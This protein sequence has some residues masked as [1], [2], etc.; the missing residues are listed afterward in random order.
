MTGLNQLAIN[1]VYTSRNSIDNNEKGQTP[2][3][4]TTKTADNEYEA[5][6]NLRHFGYMS[7]RIGRSR[8]VDLVPVQRLLVRLSAFAMVRV[9]LD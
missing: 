5:F 9:T 8:A 7:S 6:L 3:K 4:Q 1:L 2:Q